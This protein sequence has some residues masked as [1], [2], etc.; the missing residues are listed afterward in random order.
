MNEIWRCMWHHLANCNFQSQRES[1]GPPRDLFLALVRPPGPMISVINCDKLECDLNIQINY[2]VSKGG[3]KRS[4]DGPQLR[5]GGTQE[6]SNQQ[7]LLC[8]YPETM[9]PGGEE[10]GCG[11]T[12]AARSRFLKESA[13]PCLVRGHPHL[14]SGGCPANQLGQS[15]GRGWTDAGNKCCLK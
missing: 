6:G 5:A 11:G 9:P 10:E 1:L 12:E 8:T 2:C 15:C 4:L 13:R 7:S 3:D 14:G